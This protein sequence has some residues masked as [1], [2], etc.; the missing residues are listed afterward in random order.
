MFLRQIHDPAL[1]QYA[2]LIGCQRTG[3]A[4]VID[5][6]RDVDRYLQLARENDL[7]L[8]SVADTHIHAD[9]LSGA[10]ELVERHGMKGYFSAEGG[11]EWQFEWAKGRKGVTL[12][13]DGDSFHVGKIEIK[14]LLTPGHTPEH[15]SFLVI[16]HG[17]GADD[18]PMALLS[19]DFLFVGDVGRPDL[20]ESAAGQAGAMKPAARTLYESLRR[21]AALPGFLQVLPAHGAGSACGKSLG[22]V[23][24]SVLDYERRHNSALRLALEGEREDFVGTILDGQPEPPPY[25]A[26]MKRDNRRG[27]ALLAD[28]R[29]PEPRRI[30]ADELGGWVEAEG[31]RILDLR[32]DREAFMERHARGALFAPRSGGRHSVAAGSYVDEDEAVLLLVNSED[33]VAPVVRDLIRIGLDR[34][35]AWMPVGEALE[36]GEWTTSIRRITTS[37]LGQELEGGGQVLDVRGAGEFAAG[38]V[39]DAVNVAHTRLLP[40]LGEVPEGRLLVHCET[41][42]RAAMAAAFLASEGREVVHVDGEFEDMPEDLKA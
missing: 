39:K 22:A 23:P 1:A 15:L 21:T 3:E 11:D 16:D 38:H 2:Y 28:G 31:R 34:V 42:R 24:S 18:D 4:V 25:F 37:E 33:E 17:G 8:T 36:A 7:E 13:R 27:P 41:G 19:G 40:R 9:Y 5:P 6:E 10:R 14:A 29:L 26:R 35:E 20:L 30:S 32:S 12:L